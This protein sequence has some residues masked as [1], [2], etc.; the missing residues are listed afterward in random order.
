MSSISA[1]G[2]NVSV[3]SWT[4]RPGS[5]RSSGGIRWCATLGLALTVCCAQAAPPRSSS[6]YTNLSGADCTVVKENKETGATTHR[7]KGIGGWD[8]HVLYDD[9]RMSIT[10][11]QPDGREHPL[12]YWSVVTRGY[13]SLGPRAEWRVPE[14]GSDR[15]QPVGLI[16]RVNA[17]ET[18][19]GAPRKAVSYLAVTRLRGATVCTT[20]R[21]PP[22]PDANER[23]RRA[24]DNAA[25]TPCLAQ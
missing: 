25:G 20:D 7:C 16:V 1:G 23:A 24:A 18:S 21:I 11:I 19:D 6:V 14:S 9:Q 10:V 2:W 22:G 3:G 5:R 12:N 15:G 8:L 4:G 13:S 17:S